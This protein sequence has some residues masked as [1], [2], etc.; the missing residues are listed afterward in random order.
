M[1]QS[2]EFVSR[3]CEIKSLNFL[4]FVYLVAEMVFRIILKHVFVC[5]ISVSRL[6]RVFLA[7]SS[8]QLLHGSAGEVQRRNQHRYRGDRARSAPLAAG[9]SSLPERD[10]DLSAA[11]RADRLRLQKPR[12]RLLPGATITIT[13][14]ICNHAANNAFRT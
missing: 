11:P 9:A 5:I 3:N 12:H 6:R 2:Y 7:G 8:S 14:N 4:S 13:V 1:C 10:G